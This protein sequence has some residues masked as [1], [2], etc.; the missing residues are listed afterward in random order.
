LEKPY[1]TIVIPVRNDNHG[2]DFIKR[3]QNC[4]YSVF[5]LT[6]KYNFL[7]ELIV[8]EWNT[9]YYKPSII[10]NIDL[11]TKSDNCSV[12]FIQVTPVVHSRY[13]YSERLSIYQ[14]IAKNVGIRRSS[15]EF[16]L[17]TNADII[18]SEELFSFLYKKKLRRNCIYRTVRFDVDNKSLDFLSYNDLI[19]YCKSNIIRINGYVTV[20][21]NEYHG[22]EFLWIDILGKV[23]R[24]NLFK[25]SFEKIDPLFTN[26]CG[27]FQLMH[28]D[29]WFELRGYPELD[30]Y[31]FHLDSILEYQAHYSGIKEEILPNDQCIYH[32]EHGSGFIPE[33]IV[34]FEKK[35]PAGFRITDQ[36]L[37]YYR[38]SIKNSKIKKIF[39]NENWG[40]EKENL[41]Y[42]VNEFLTPKI[43]FVAVPKSFENEFENI[44]FN[45]INS[46]LNLSVEKEIFLLCDSKFNEYIKS[47]KIKYIKE[48]K[49]TK[50]GKPSLKSVFDISKKYIQT[51][52]VVYINS[53]II[54]LDDFSETI[55]NIIK[56]INKNFLLIGKR[57]NIDF[58]DKIDFYNIHWWDDIN[59]LKKNGI[60]DTELSLD[61]F[62]FHKSFLGGNIPDLSI[63]GMYW[64]NWLVSK[65]F[66]DKCIIID[67]SATLSAIHQNHGYANNMTIRDI[68]NTDMANENFNLMGGNLNKKHL[69][70]VKIF[71]NWTGFYDKFGNCLD[72]EKVFSIHENNFESKDY[73]DDFQLD[74]I[75]NYILYIT[76]EHYTNINNML[77]QISLFDNNPDIL[78]SIAL[79]LIEIEDKMNFDQFTHIMS[80][81]AE[82]GYLNGDNLIG[83]KYKEYS[84]KHILYWEN[85]ISSGDFNGILILSLIYYYGLGCKKNEKKGL[86]LLFDYYLKTNQTYKI[87][88]LF[89]RLFFDAKKEKY[90]KSFVDFFEKENNAETYYFLGM[91]Y[92][93]GIGNFIKKD[94][95]NAL[96]YFIKSAETGLKEG[97]NYLG[98]KYLM[99]K[100]IDKA[101]HCF[102]IGITYGDDLSKENLNYILNKL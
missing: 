84:T 49:Y 86:K 24:Y 44:Q 8:V 67:T 79:Y 5:Y 100:N 14:M 42:E 63:G 53:D 81:V 13:K 97:L 12:K 72:L 18:F 55:K 64:D 77:E 37:E 38:F 59:N 47:E 68:L 28:R 92:C 91:L 31:S 33:K 65:G 41:I 62:I 71:F 21:S 11:T 20:T 17:C 102:N 99:D 15:G 22:N 34:D 36:Q 82:I 7:I 90:M 74:Y 76:G 101:K 57:V 60:T 43:T 78:F 29:N 32:I 85:K 3:F 39:N 70:H 27:D 88:L 26:A 93:R 75:S 96:Q 95:D 66:K 89:F 56:K 35:Y 52:F 45:A 46:W 23:Q 69:G 10:K 54:L 25:N 4:I 48:L 80:R 19:N 6:Q 50:F 1:L 83:L 98:I 73:N 40:L 9:P 58:N 87:R 51:D 94:E 16:I 2:G 61:Y 30:Q